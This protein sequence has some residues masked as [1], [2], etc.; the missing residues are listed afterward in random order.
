MRLNSRAYPSGTA[1]PFPRR[2]VQVGFLLWVALAAV[3]REPDAQQLAPGVLTNAESFWGVPASER[4][5]LHRL[6]TQFLV[7]YFDP[8]WKVAFSR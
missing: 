5:L 1:K 7:Y 8:A 4:S 2:V 3:G 6:K